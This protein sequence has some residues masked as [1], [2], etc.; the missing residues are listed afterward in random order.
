MSNV[1]CMF[2]PGLTLSI[3]RNGI[4][5]GEVRETDGEPVINLMVERN[6]SWTKLTFMDIKIIQ[7]NW[8]SMMENVNNG[9]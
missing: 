1:V 8:N 4:P 9:A 6:Q 2:Q 5:I 7:D 3:A